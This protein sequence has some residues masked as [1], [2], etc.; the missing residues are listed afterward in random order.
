[1]NRIVDRALPLWGLGGADYHLVAARENS[2]FRVQSGDRT[3]ALRLHRVGYR[4]DR[5]LRSELAW[6]D[7]VSTGGIGVPAPVPAASGDLLHV[8]GGIQ[9][10]V[11]SW[12]NGV[13][14]KKALARRDA[15][16]RAALF[17]E[18][19]RQIARLHD[20]ADAWTPPADFTRCAW[21]REGLLGEAPLWGR[22]WDNPLLSGEDRRLLLKLR[23]AADADLQRLEGVLDYGLIHADL[24]AENIMVDGDLVQMI[25]FDD[26]GLGYRLFEIATAL[27]K[28]MGE[29]DY[30]ALKAALTNGYQSICPIDLAPL[31]LFM[32]I[33]AATYVG[34]NMERL[35]EDGAEARN[36]RLIADARACA[37]TYLGG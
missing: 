36:A 21:D 33:R 5:E 34:W 16:G 10:D 17:H 23:K 31:D 11:L 37:Q 1:M 12:L 13:S 24:V 32:A 29:A 26:G 3:V 19:G 27:V 28:Y 4:T 25:D 15:E 30:P 2:V 20:I 35:A 14:V 7:A 8:V 22:F 6:M 18:I 9:V